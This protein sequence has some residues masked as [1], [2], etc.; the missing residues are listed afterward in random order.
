MPAQLHFE[1]SPSS[2][3]RVE[4]R[5][6][7]GEDAQSTSLVRVSQ[8]AQ[9]ASSAV[10]RHSTLPEVGLALTNKTLDPS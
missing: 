7:F 3:Q 1:V 9:K 8:L 6:E 10:L 2:V 4:D 5:R